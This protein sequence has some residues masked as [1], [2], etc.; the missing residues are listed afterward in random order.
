MDDNPFASFSFQSNELPKSST[1]T[2][3]KFFTKTDEK[4]TLVAN[5][6][7]HAIKTEQVQDE[8]HDKVQDKSQEKVQE[9]KEKNAIPTKGSYDP[10]WHLSFKLPREHSDSIIKEFAFVP[11]PPPRN[12]K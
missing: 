5:K 2:V 6:K 8:A 7:D 3:S 12:H 4:S 11:P 1:G 9:M 10:L